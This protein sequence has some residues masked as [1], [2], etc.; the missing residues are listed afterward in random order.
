MQRAKIGAQLP[1]G[2]SSDNLDIRNRKLVMNAEVRGQ[3]R[4]AS[5]LIWYHIWEEPVHDQICQAMVFSE[6][7]GPASRMGGGR[8]RESSGLH[9][10]S[11]SVTLLSPLS[12]KDTLFPVWL[13][14]P[15][16]TLVQPQTQP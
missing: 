1:K 3:S 9:E 2:A 15:H 12:L 14:A 13:L 10:G 7:S 5:R 16:T 8:G 11:P 4:V 6:G